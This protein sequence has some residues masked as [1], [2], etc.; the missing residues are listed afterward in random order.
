VAPAAAAARASLVPGVA[1][2]GQEGAV[3]VVPGPLQRGEGRVGGGLAL[4]TLLLRR[5]RPAAGG[6]HQGDDLR[7][8][9]GVRHGGRAGGDVLVGAGSG[10]AGHQRLLRR[11]ISTTGG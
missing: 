6:G 11:R 9:R 2:V 1:V 3:E 7:V 8:V 5:D 4:E 10:A